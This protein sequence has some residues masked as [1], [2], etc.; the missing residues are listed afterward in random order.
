MTDRPPREFN[1][2]YESY[3]FNGKLVDDMAHAE[4]LAAFKVLAARYQKLSAKQQ[5]ANK[6]ACKGVGYKEIG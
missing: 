5:D 6:V 2:S 3:L 4:L 1:E